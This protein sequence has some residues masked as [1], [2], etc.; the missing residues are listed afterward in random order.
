ML[1]IDKNGGIDDVLIKV[2]AK[3]FIHRKIQNYKMN[4]HKENIVL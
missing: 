1:R 3:S 2:K 4:I